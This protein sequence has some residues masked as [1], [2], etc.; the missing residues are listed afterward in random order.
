MAINANS[1]DISL[2][3]KSGEGANGSSYNSK[4]DPDV[5]VK[6]YNLGY[7]VSTIVTEAEVA[8]KVYDL[9]IASPEPGQLVTDGERIGIMFRRIPG[10][11]SFARALADNPQRCKELATQFAHMCRKL[12]STE[13]PEGLFPTAKA[14][15]MA[16][17]D[18][19]TAF[20]AEEKGRIA[21]FINATPDCRTAVHGDMHFGNAVLDGEGKGLWIDLGYFACGYPMF[22][23]GMTY[24]VTHHNSD[25]FT[26]ENFH[27]H[28]PLAL[29]FWNNFIPVYLGTD[30]PEA[31]AEKER[32]I[33]AF[34]ALK[35]LLIEYN[36][37]GVLFDWC[38]QLFYDT[39]L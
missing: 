27:I 11:V 5:M 37:G 10:K 13:C 2:F 21:A 4:T 19:D 12:H 14:Q 22:D 23:L 8:R 29:E 30:D 38:K 17:L 28:N 15:Y 32:E 31:I 35:T 25:E 18:A 34:A 16:L 9:G 20:T 1:I 33:Q 24:I 39:I 7:D 3:E 26:F 6:M 36:C